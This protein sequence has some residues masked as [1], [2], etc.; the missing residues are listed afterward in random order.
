MSSDIKCVLDE[1]AT[2]DEIRKAKHDLRGVTLC[3]R[4]VQLMQREP[5][6]DAAHTFIDKE[7]TTINAFVHRHY[8]DT[9]SVEMWFSYLR[10]GGI[11]RMCKRC[12]KIAV[13]TFQEVGR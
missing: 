13:E 3:G 1:R 12:K 9:W 7:K 2:N 6:Y 11:Y 5:D 10:A 8:M 4:K